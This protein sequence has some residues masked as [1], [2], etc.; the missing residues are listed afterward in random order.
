MITGRKYQGFAVSVKGYSHGEGICQDASAFFSDSKM[1]VISVCDGHGSEH[2]FRSDK[3]SKIACSIAVEAIKEF[4]YN[5]PKILET[6]S[7]ELDKQIRH[8][9]EHIIY[10]WNEETK[11]DF[12]SYPLSVEEMTHLKEKDRDE[13]TSSLTISDY[14]NIY[15]TTFIA[16]VI[17]KDF[18]LIL[19]LGD[20]NA[21]I[22]DKRGLTQP[23]PEDE[24]IHFQF[25]TSICQKDAISNFRHSYG[26]AS[27][28]AMILTSDGFRNSFIN[29]DYFTDTIK[30]ILSDI[31]SQ[32]P[33]AV[34]A[35]LE[36]D[37]PVLSKKG[38]GDDI[39]LALSYD[40]KLLANYR[41]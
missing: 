24:N 3:G 6:N 15:G 1:A 40:T 11:K 30:E 14:A 27:P 9:K 2:H 22:L 13:Y 12:D 7:L 31:N 37:L 25:T 35:G 28:A 29:D 20:G 16:G 10:R 32:D 17:T 18:Y 36:E 39:S 5:N 19:Q 4:I 23:V 21:L 8:L 26:F 34:R 41:L 33:E 38:S